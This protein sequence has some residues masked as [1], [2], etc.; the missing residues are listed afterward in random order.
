MRR[1]S[2]RGLGICGRVT[3]C[4]RCRV[5]DSSKPPTTDKERAER[6]AQN[7]QHGGLVI[8]RG[9]YWE[10]N[11]LWQDHFDALPPGATKR[12]GYPLGSGAYVRTGRFEGT[13][14]GYGDARVY[15]W[16]PDD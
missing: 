13:G 12:T 8:L 10:G 3:I 9:G 2:Q 11:T 7:A 14:L 5:A 15:Q 6:A 4:G 1:R 16:T